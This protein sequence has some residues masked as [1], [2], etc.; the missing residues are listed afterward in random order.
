MRT[1][2]LTNEKKRDAQVS[3]E[4]RKKPP[5]VRRVLDDGQDYINI[6]LLKQNLNLSFDTL[7]K[8]YD[9]LVQMGNALIESDPEVD[10]EL[11][12]KRKKKKKK[13]YLNKDNKI[14]YR[15]NMVQIIKDPTGKEIERRDLAKAM[16]NVTGESVV[17]WSGKK[18]PKSAAI[19]RFVFQHKLQ[20][21][22]ISGLTYDFLYEM[23]KNLQQTDS[24]MLVG[25][26]KKG[27]EPLILTQGGEP[28]RGFLEG[29]V[30]GDKYCLILHLTNMEVRM[31]NAGN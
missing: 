31:I 11:I 24:L 17:H 22:H 6:K 26:G 30:S 25:G 10:L 28:Y 2:N 5:E 23:A 9:D 12:G 1:I 7:S 14:A 13:L 21:K 3:M 27:T 19:R 29:R 15:V 20:I 8:N 18:F 4:P 16:S